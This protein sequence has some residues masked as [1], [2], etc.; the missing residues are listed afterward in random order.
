MTVPNL[1]T[2]I[3]I[4]LAPIF[5]IYLINEQ[6]LSALIVFLLCV[7]SDCVDGLVAR[8]FQQKSRLGVYLDP[9][10]DKILLV[11]SFIVL[12]VEGFLPSWLTVMVISR[13]VMILLGVFILFLNGLEFNIRPSIISKINTCLQFI[14]VIAVLSKDYLSYSSEFY[15]Y[16]FC[17]TALFTIS[18]GLHYMHYWFRVMGEDRT[19]TED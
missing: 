7:V 9:L 1:I 10:A 13:D 8:I 2:A 6:F 5:I 11:S 4:I 16:L 14:T 17:L 15:F 12:S 19:S 3:R 18:S